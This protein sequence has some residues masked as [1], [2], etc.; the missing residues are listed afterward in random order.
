[1]AHYWWP[2]NTFSVT[3]WSQESCL[4]DSQFYTQ[5]SDKC[6][7]ITIFKYWWDEQMNNYFH[8]V[9]LQPLLLCLRLNLMY[10]LYCHPRSQAL[11]CFKPMQ[12]TFATEC[13]VH[14][15]YLNELSFILLINIHRMN[16]GMNEDLQRKWT[17]YINV[18][19][20]K[21]Q[22]TVEE[23]PNSSVAVRNTFLSA[24]NLGYFSS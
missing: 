21:T 12:I 4:F 14:E 10:T 1:M 20:N 24:F 5:P 11:Y 2:I 6:L 23:H 18:S 3:K 8:L 15:F 17:T 13:K 9:I 22:D 7:A 16:K 19:I